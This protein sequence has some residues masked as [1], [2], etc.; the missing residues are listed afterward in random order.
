MVRTE[1][2]LGR[3]LRDRSGSVVQMFALGLPAL[4]MLS[5]GAVELSI[6][7]SHKS[8]LQSAADAAALNGRVS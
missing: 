1:L 7:A 5:V 8:A 2:F 3:L 4:A 6:V